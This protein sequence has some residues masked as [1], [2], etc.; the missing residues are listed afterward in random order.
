MVEKTL[1]LLAAGRGN[2]F[3]GLKQLH[4]FRPQNAFLA[5]YALFDAWEAGFRC[6][7]AIVSPGTHEAFQALFKERNLEDVAYCVLQTDDG[8]PQRWRNERTKPWGTGQALLTAST[9]IQTPFVIVNGDD[10][11]GREAYQLASDFIDQHSS[12]AALVAYPLKATL[13]PN[14]SVSR[15]LCTV[16]NNNVLR[17]DEYTCETQGNKV[18]GKR[19]V[20][21]SQIPETPSG[22]SAGTADAVVTLDPQQPTSLNFFVL[23]KTILS[24]LKAL[25]EQF[26]KNVTDPKNEEFFLPTVVQA[27]LKQQHKDLH[28]LANPCGRWLGVTYADD[29]EAVE[30]FLTEQTAAGRYPKMFE[31][32]S[33]GDN[34]NGTRCD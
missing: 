23:P 10:F 12:E 21:S 15:A 1:V 33:F 4:R 11:Y 22:G 34:L 26:L 28:L 9:F 25:W 6:F 5:E 31:A 3:G 19:K 7:I 16:E 2:R 14:G 18:V 17:L 30:K 8:V 13:S 32:S 24:P 29:T 20:C 27:V